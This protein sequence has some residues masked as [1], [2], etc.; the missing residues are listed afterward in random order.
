MNIAMNRRRFIQ[1]TSAIALGAM[2]CGAGRAL[3]QPSNEL[4]VSVYGGDVGK[5]NVEAYVKPFEAET[6]IKVTAI[7]D[8]VT[9][10]QIELMVT[11]NNT[12]VDVV[13][14][15]AATAHT[16]NLKS[17][18][19]QIDYSIFKKD[20]LDAIVDFAKKPFGVAGLVYGIPMVYSTEKFPPTG[21]QPTSW[22]DFWDVEKFPGVRTLETGQGGG[23][24]PWEEALL[25]DGVAADKIYPMDID[26]IFASLDKIKPHIRKW[27]TSGSEGQQLFHD[28]AVDI[29]NC[30]DGRANLL[31]D[32]GAPLKINRNQSKL[33][34]DY[35]VIPKGSPNVQNAQRFIEFA[36]RADRQAAFAK[37]VPYG[38]INRNAFKLLPEE[39][40]LKLPSHPKL[41]ANSIV[42]DLQ[43]YTEVGSD[44]QSNID[45]L[46]QRWNEW[47]L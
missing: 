39:V 43:W 40:G 18:L 44:G 12:T 27:W 23:E 34:N 1:S 4:R 13:G 42:M 32:Q 22:A 8:D 31:I 41:L 2:S 21:P 45:R 29:G 33:T 5:A 24:G 38:P 25:A 10:P 47:I 37:L 20:E 36:T 11:S 17:L 3:A 19:E 7:P 30:Y 6:G 35:W 14:A 16:A 28:K 9:L 26:R 46:V 15:D